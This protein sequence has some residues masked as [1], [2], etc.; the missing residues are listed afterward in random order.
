MSTACSCKQLDVFFEIGCEQL[1]SVFE[2]ESFQFQEAQLLT[3]KPLKK[4]DLDE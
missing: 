1:E 4:R 3:A 2:L